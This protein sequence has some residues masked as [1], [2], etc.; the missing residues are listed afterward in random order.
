M[1]NRGK[2]GGQSMALEHGFDGARMPFGHPIPFRVFIHHKN[3]AV[4]ILAPEQHDRVMREPVIKGREPFDGASIVEIVDD[5]DL[6]AES[7]EE[8]SGGN[9][10]VAVAPGAFF[11]TGERIEH[12]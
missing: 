8:L 7:E 5:M 6:A 3:I 10:P 11:P 12:P 4:A 1:V 2:A 9:V